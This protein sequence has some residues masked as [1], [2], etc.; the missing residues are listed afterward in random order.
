MVKDS[1]LSLDIRAWIEEN[2]ENVV[3]GFFKKI[4]QVGEREFLFKIY[5]GET[6][7]LYVNL[8][9]WIYFQSKETPMEPSM[10]VMF[11]RKRFSGKRIV[12]FHQLNFDRIVVFETHD[13]YSLILEL[14]GEGN[15]IVTRDGIIER[16]FLEREWRHRSILRGMEY[17]PPPQALDPQRDI[18]AM[19][20][21]MEDSDMDLVRFLARR[22]N[23]GKYA[24]EACLRANVDKNS[25][26]LSEEECQRIKDAII[27]LFNFTGGYIYP[28]FFSPIEL[29]MFDSP[30]KRFERFNDALASYLKEEA[31]EESPEVLR[32]RRRIEEI[33]RS[34]EEFERQ[35]EENRLK[36]D[37]IYAHFQEIEEMI[38]RARRG[39]IPLEG[40]KLLRVSFDGVEIE[41]DVDKSVGENAGMYYDRA[42]KMR[43]KVKGAKDAL[44]KAREEI[45]AVKKREE[46]K[47]K[48]IRKNR[49][50]FWFEKYRWFVSSE[51]FL[52]I[53]GRDAK[54][55]E[56]VVKKHLGS[57]DLYMHAD[58]HGAPSVVIKTEGREVGE[59]T[60]YE[61][62]QFAVSMSKAWNAGFGNL[63]AYWVYP[64]QVSKMG[65]SGEYVAKGAWV[66]HGKRNYIHKVPLRLGVGEINYQGVKMVMCGA[67]DAVKS[68]S[69]KYFII[70]PG[71]IRKEEFAK[72][73]S[74]EFGIPTE[75][76]LR[77]LPP[78]K[79]RI[80][81]SRG[82][83]TEK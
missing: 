17:V 69:E 28:G 83:K 49:R 74:R 67:V 39:E 31:E 55:N 54:T 58:I 64:S 66:V 7:P 45:K 37:T 40:S 52:I 16:A 81:E 26:S 43:E 53:A 22:F 57:K 77:I 12:K 78:G 23:L 56:E 30:L 15:I 32:I 14:F 9:G 20:Q 61:A 8:R 38:E 71:D 46:K 19:C 50:R 82:L 51:D 29:R 79:I 44:A 70:E 10:F 27:S 3:D 72:T 42:K 62:A 21:E 47:K 24:E 33:E 60:L 68:R 63:S 2:R 13:G 80:V 41:L 35:E 73:L 5:K 18:D 6:R 76:A 34:I 75:E 11:L 48:E 65:E 59:R 25:K 1:M 4:Y 36:G